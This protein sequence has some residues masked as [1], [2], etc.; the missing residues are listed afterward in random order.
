MSLG[1][2]LRLFIGGALVS[3]L[4]VA[5]AVETDHG[6][7]GGGGG[8]GGTTSPPPSGTSGGSS[9]PSTNPILA[10]VD[11]GRTMN[12]QPGDGVG[13]FTEYNAGGHWHVWW[14][15]DTNKTGATCP[16]DVTISVASGAISNPSVDESPTVGALNASTPSQI[17]I[18]TTTSTSTD[19]VHFDTVPGAVITLGASIGGAYDGSFFFFVQGGKVNGGFTGTL[20]DPIK[21]E[22]SAP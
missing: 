6:Y 4:A 18:R 2:C 22:G 17:E 14:T 1:S 5:C 21:L 8:Y 11:T 10:D 7:G 3:G 13:V 15:C 16:M 12:A 19:G 9:S 20:T